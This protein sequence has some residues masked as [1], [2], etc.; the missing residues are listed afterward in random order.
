MNRN[1]TV[2][3]LQAAAAQILSTLAPGE[4]LTIVHNNEALAHIRPAVAPPSDK[5]RVPGFAKGKVWLA[6]DF[7]AELPDAS[8]AGAE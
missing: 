1:I 7:D 3:E 5:P 4:E 8:A 6:D 2:A